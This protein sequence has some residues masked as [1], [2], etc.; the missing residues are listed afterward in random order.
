LI[1]INRFIKKREKKIGLPPGTPVYMGEKKKD[2]VE[3]SV[4]DYDKQ[5][6]IKKEYKKI[7]DCFAYKDTSTVSWINIDGVHKAEIIEKL[8]KFFKLHPLVAEDIMSP[9][10]RPKMEEFEDYIFIVLNMLSYHKKEEIVKEE[11]VSFILGKNY[12]ISFQERQGDVFDHIK[13]RIEKGRGR[14]R[15]MGPDYLTHSLLDAVVDN[16]FLVL[17]EIGERIEELEEKLIADSRPDTLQKIHSLKREMIFL[18]RSV[19]PLRE[20]ISGLQKTE[21]DLIRRDTIR[22][23]QDI[24]DHTIQMMDTIEVFRDMLFSMDDTYLSNIS[25]R[26]NEVMKVLTIIATIFVP[27]TFLTGVYGMNFKFMPELSWRG[28]YY[29]VL[30]AMGVIVILMVIYLKKKKWL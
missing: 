11:Q 1:K 2:R 23:L 21:S 6:F 19:W 7:E 4:I 10:H 3:I 28:G 5:Q 26:M 27:L 25:N 13:E 18:R 29:I 8:G 16:Y 14:I 30:G 12:V 17:E 15:T 24:Y 9:G 20:M 22:F